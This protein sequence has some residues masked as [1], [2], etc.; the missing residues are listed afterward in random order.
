MGFDKFRPRLVIVDH[1]QRWAVAAAIGLGDLVDGDIGRFGANVGR[2]NA[3][4]HAGLQILRLGN[5]ADLHIDRA[6]VRCIDD[7]IGAAVEFVRKTL[8]DD[9]A[10]DGLGAG[11][12]R[13]VNRIG[14]DRPFGATCRQLAVHGLDDVAALAHA[15]Q[16]RLQLG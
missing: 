13:I 16:C 11:V 5:R 9:P 15:P 12:A 1:M 6:A 3:H 8:G 2:F 4:H 7:R 10:F 14:A